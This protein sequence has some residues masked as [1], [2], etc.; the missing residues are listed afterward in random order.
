MI[1]EAN[2]SL[3]IGNPPFCC[4]F[5]LMDGR[6]SGDVPVDE[7]VGWELDKDGN[8]CRGAECK[9]GLRLFLLMALCNISNGQ[10]GL[11]AKGALKYI[12]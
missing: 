11:R 4:I 5:A 2:S 9:G 8:I 12:Y 3:L 1:E 10:P 7:L 6:I